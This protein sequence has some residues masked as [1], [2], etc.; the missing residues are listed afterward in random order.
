MI[1]RPRTTPPATQAPLLRKEGNVWIRAPLLDE[2]GWRKAPGW[3]KGLIFCQ[4]QMNTGVKGQMLHPSRLH[5]RSSIAERRRTLRSSLTPA[6]ATL[7]R[8]LQR[9]QFYG[10]KFRRQHSIGPYVVDF[11]C[12]RERLAIELDGSAHDNETA[13]ARDK[14]RERFLHSAGLKVLRLENRHVFENPEG[15]LDLI[16]QH[17]RSD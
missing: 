10:R 3:W 16:K 12:P 1:P 6:E 15:V 8:L 5:N 7:W 9:S 11:Y 4:P 13:F 17:F 2:E 14:A